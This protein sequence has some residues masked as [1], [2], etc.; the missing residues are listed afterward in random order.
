MG[1]INLLFP[2]KVRIFFL[3][4]LFIINDSSEKTRTL[5]TK[6]TYIRQLKVNAT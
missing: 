1:K 6:Y 4:L 2:Q 3:F 5:T